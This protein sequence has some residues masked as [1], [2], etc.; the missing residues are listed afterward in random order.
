MKLKFSCT[1]NV[2]Y[3]AMQRIFSDHA[4]RAFYVIEQGMCIF[5]YFNE[6][7]WITFKLSDI[8]FDNRFYLHRF[9]FIEF[10]CWT[11]DGLIHIKKNSCRYHSNSMDKSIYR[12]FFKS[13]IKIDEI[14]FGFLQC[15]PWVVTLHNTKWNFWLPLHFFPS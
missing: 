1:W 13:I 10:K 12:K 14:L 15:I 11:L 8:I 3:S 2:C 4:I 6:W 9:C 5:W 7:P